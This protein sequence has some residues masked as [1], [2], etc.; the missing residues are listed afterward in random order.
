MSTP[1]IEP[2]SRIARQAESARSL[3]VQWQQD[4]VDIQGVLASKQCACGMPKTAHA[5]ESHTG[6]I[7]IDRSCRRYRRDER[8]ALIEKAL[9][10][11]ERTFRQDAHEYDRMTNQHEKRRRA[12]KE[13]G[14][15]HV[16]P[17][18]RS[19]CRKAIEYR[20]RPPEGYVPAP[21]DKQ[22]AHMGS[23]VHEGFRRRRKALYPW[24]VFEQDVV[25]PGLDR[26]GRF[27]EYDEIIARVVDCK[28]AGKW[29]WEQVGKHGVP[30]EERQQA[31]IYAKALR[32][33]GKPVDEVEIIYINRENGTPE[34]FLFP[35]SEQDAN[36]G[37]TWLRQVIETLDLG[38]PLPRDREGPSTDPICARY[39]PARRHCWNMDE[40]EDR[41]ASPEHV[42]LIRHDPDVEFALL[43]YDD[44][45]EAEGAAKREKERQKAL[46]E[47]AEHGQYGVMIYGHSG[48]RAGEP[49]LDVEKR[50][51]QLETFYDLPP[52]Q[53]PPL[54]DLKPPMRTPVSPRT[55]QVKRERVAKTTKRQ[56]IQDAID[57]GL[58]GSNAERQAAGLEGHCDRCLLFGHR[59]AHPDRSCAEVGCDTPHGDE[60]PEGA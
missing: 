20:E 50:I 25:V 13:E 2:R 42:T 53:R 33:M 51:E 9:I 56:A 57:A 24:R 6:G 31:M 4:G 34:S 32:E 11:R 45:R 8:H 27:D 40:A 14:A 26:P 49:V 29:K 28:T 60:P 35:Y 54:A 48:G 10:G 16:G 12:P 55:L 38:M 47:G 7:T 52:D 5:G 43:R 21:T 23:I 15:W 1:T 58:S 17:S 18:D 36:D 46:L 19:A 39:C 41:G 22:A 3:L 37:L 30:T 59:K 44:A